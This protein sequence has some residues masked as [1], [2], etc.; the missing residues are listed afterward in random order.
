MKSLFVALALPLSLT[1][2]GELD[3]LLSD[4]SSVVVHV[5]TDAAT[6]TLG[7][8]EPVAYKVSQSNVMSDLFGGGWAFE[9]VDPSKTPFKFSLEKNGGMY[10]CMGCADTPVNLVVVTAK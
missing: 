3:L 8:R 2:C 6:L 5:T 10:V 4:K 7:G 1:A 9:A